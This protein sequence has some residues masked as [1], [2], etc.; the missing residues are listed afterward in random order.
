MGNGKKEIT[1]GLQ[2]KAKIDDALDSVKVLK[3]ELSGFELSKGI[4]AEF[5]KEFKKIETELDELQRKTA[6][7]EI[8][9]VDA[10]GA[11]KALDKIEKDWNYLVSKLSSQGL[12]GKTLKEDSAALHLLETLQNS[13]TKGIREAEAQ[14]LKLSKQLEKA[15]QHEQEILETQKDQHVVSQS[16]LKDQQTKASI[17][18]QQAK[19]ALKARK[20]AEKA[21]REKIAGSNGKYT[22]DDI[23]RKGSGLRKTEAYRNF[24]AAQAAHDAADKTAK[25][26]KAKTSA[27]VT[28]EMQTAAAQEARQAVEAANKALEDYKANALEVAK[29]DAF[30]K[31]KQSLREMAEFSSIDWG[32]LGIDLDE[33]KTIDELKEALS[34]LRVEAGTKVKASVEKMDD[35]IEKTSGNFRQMDKEVGEAKEGL[36]EYHKEASQTEA[37]EAKIK[38]FLGFAGAAQVLRNAVRDAMET[39]KELD[40][41][42]T[43]MA[44]VTDLTVGDYW[45]QLSEYSQQASDLGVSI[46]S[47]YK[48]ATLYYQQGLK[49]NEVTAISAETL[50]MA[51]IAGID[52][53]DATDKMTAALRGFNMELN[54]TSAQRV[55][56]VYSELAAITAADTQ[57]IANAM[58][59]TASIASNAGMEFETTAAFLSQIIE[60]TRESA[61]TAGTA[62]KTVI[63]RFQE[64]IK[65]PAEIGEV[66][67]EIVDANKIETA[68]RSV[69]VSLRD[70]SGQFRDLDDVF[71]ELSSKWDSLDTNTQRYIATI[72]A[73]SRQQSRFIAMMSN[74][75]RTQELVAAAN[76]SAGASNKQFE[77]TMESLEA[78]IAKLENAW[79]EF[80]MGIMNSDLVKAGV[81]IL[82]KLLEIIN[83]ATSGFNGM[84]GS[85]TKILGILT[86]FKLGK[87]IFNKLREPMVKFF[88]DIVR[89]AGA[90]GEKAGRAAQDGLNK[91][92]QQKNDKG[93]SKLPEG[94]VYDKN[95]RMHKNGKFI[96]ATEQRRI[97]KEL[98]AQEAQVPA[99][100]RAAGWVWEKTGGA[101]IKSSIT[102]I[103][104]NNK[105]RKANAAKIAKKQEEI[106]DIQF[107][108]DFGL[109]E[110]EAEKARAEIKGLESDIIGLEKEQANLADQ[111]TK[112]WES[113]GQGVQQAGAAVT[114]V[115]VAVSVL[116]GVF[117][118]LGL[119]EVGEAFSKIGNVVTLV[120]AGISTLGTVIPAV[121]AVA[122]AAGITTQ[123][124]WGW[125]GLILA[126]VAVLVTTVMLIFK[127]IED[128]DPNKKL[129]K[130][131]KAADAAADGAKRAAEA[132]NELNESLSSLDD[133]YKGLDEMTK[134]TEEWN[135]AVQDVNS[136][137]LDLIDKYPELAGFVEN[138]G[139][140]LTLDVDSAEVKD[141]MQAYKQDEIVAK[142]ASIGAKA[143]LARANADYELNTMD[144]KVFE[145]FQTD[146]QGAATWTAIGNLAAAT[147]LGAAG[148]AAIGAGT[149]ALVGAPVFGVGA[150]AGAGAGAIIGAI[151]GGVSGLIGGLASFQYTVDQVEK[152]NE[153]NRKNVE[154]L[155]QAYAN[156]ETGETVEEIADYIERNGI[157]VGDAAEQMAQSL[158][159]EAS[160][161]KEFGETLNAL[162][163]Q[164]K[165]YYQAMA[166]NA[167]QLLDL[168]TITEKEMNQINTV[169][170]ED[171]MKNQ[172]EAEKARL[173]AE[174][175]NKDGN[176]DKEKEDFAK[177]VYGDKARVDGNKILDEKGE[178]IREFD[179][180]E[181]WIN[182]MAAA[183]ATKE[184]AE[185]ME[186]IP[187]AIKNAIRDLSPTLQETFNK[188]FEGQ[189]LTRGEL[190]EFNKALGNVNY[191]TTD[192]DGNII[193][194]KKWAELDQQTKNLW[195]SE[196]AYLR[197]LDADYSGI[198]EMWKNLSQEQK[199]AY[200]W[201]GSSSDVEGLEKAK[202]AFEATYTEIAEAQT[203]AFEEAN[204]A[205]E[206]LGITLSENLSS[207]AAQAWATSLQEASYGAVSGEV[208]ALNE[209]LN[210]VLSGMTAEQANLVMA[211]INAMDKMDASAWENLGEVLSELE[212][213]PAAEALEALSIAG[214]N[215][216]N[217]IVKVDFDTLAQDINNIYKTL[218]KT[219]E[220]K[221]SYSESDYKELIAV[222]KALKDEFIQIGDEFLYVGGTMESLTEALERNTL[223]KLSEANR[224]LEDKIAM[225]EIVDAQDYGNVEAMGRNDLLNYLTNMRHDFATEGLDIADLGVT[226]LSNETNFSKL[227]DEQLLT[228][229]T[230]V[231]GEAGKKAVYE[232]D[233]QKQVYDANVLR[234]TRN[235]ASYNAEM[236]V[237]GGEYAKAHEDALIAQAIQ[238]GGVSN[239]LIEE[240][241]KATGETKK[242]LG[243]K[244]A[245][246]V[247]KVVKNS[248]GRDAYKE[249]INKVETAIKESHQKEIDKLSEINESIND[250]NQRLIDKIQEQI[251]YDRQ[252]DALEDA[253]ENL[254]D[255]YARQAYLGMDTSGANALEQMA[256]DEE[257][258]NAEKDLEQTLVD[259]AIQNL[260][261]A[262]EKAFEQRERQI[263]LMQEQL[264]WESENGLTYDKAKQAVDDSLAAMKADPTLVWNKTAMGEILAG[265]SEAK[266]F[267]LSAEDWESS[268]TTLATAAQNW[269]DLNPKTENTTGT[270][271][272]EPKEKPTDEEKT[273]LEEKKKA[274]TIANARSAAKASLESVTSGGFAGQEQ[275]KN[276]ELRKAYEA[277]KGAGGTG[278]LEQFAQDS[279]GSGK[280]IHMNDFVREIGT[281]Y[282]DR[283]WSNDFNWE[284]GKS[285]ADDGW[286]KVNGTDYKATIN[287]TDSTAR[288]VAVARGVGENELFKYANSYYIYHGDLAYKLTHYKSSDGWVAPKFKAGGLADFTGPA[289]LD[290]TKSRPEYVL[291]A[292][293]TERFFSLVDVL[294]KFNQNKVDTKTNGNGGD[295]HFDIKINVDKLESDYDVEQLAAKI[296]KM[297]YEDAAYR[298]VNAISLIR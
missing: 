20:D 165:A 10:K 6:S 245:E 279:L 288:S 174:A 237:D 275:D 126:G 135:K 216:Y 67:G 12:L 233:Y 220:G 276:S 27:M 162:D 93:P 81:D 110:K 196:E 53:A 8:S 173:Q 34:D 199:K 75:S 298:N 258:Q 172:E 157:A 78:K 117:S 15:K 152:N 278:S 226:G 282:T 39:I 169:F 235:D 175:E 292:A 106:D 83:K 213:A 55:S 41:T 112:A 208:T 164:E 69:G 287:G 104:A 21:L 76:N 284:D 230:A 224:Q 185:A 159:S 210:E 92:K 87:T 49:A 239:T 189:P 115:G 130:A 124:A 63:A 248:A 72:A 113:L 221:R 193:D 252:Q 249:I 95:G 2:I 251:D 280:N 247:D 19:D 188:A 228:M 158:I 7:G 161:M 73:G 56:D 222:N 186:Q 43:E 30:E 13:Y 203:K 89:E 229:A 176:F 94:Y 70:T 260:A 140:V 120:G 293:Q 82:T 218:D 9:L 31:A 272:E 211:E 62:M 234:Y 97:E 33:I 40:A 253:K 131:Q 217:A 197:S 180:D 80:T 129:E 256:V 138:E 266:L 64:L 1:I 240:Y 59:K 134:G 128:N 270:G 60:T 289:W 151:A 273:K 177:S 182:E 133:K 255:L 150:A 184:A 28:K 100:K 114:G 243:K 205:A 212:I 44:V 136:S 122:S 137:V 29:I 108:L 144:D 192:Q 47:A 4:A 42:M 147:T 153:Q 156:G 109:D 262:N 225:A 232:K 283:S 18:E 116:G 103:G 154:E 171:L 61:E 231:A 268:I 127:Q 295:N 242:E 191:K 91:S 143:E 206:G 238:S 141:I 101:Q 45:D 14:Q 263:T 207:S 294:E 274:E 267:G 170:D 259:Q 90:T 187:G 195:G 52:A 244:I 271:Q 35:A 23:T 139:G 24:A 178:V 201:S 281:A 236:S 54:E 17:A 227:S 166:L 246:G 3:D 46:N 269:I 290:G 36:E 96:D 219:K 250:V 179:S 22:A 181:A 125:I 84:A 148:G 86:V 119:E 296:R 98:E 68:L 200:G 77:K 167:Q 261:D 79:H 123:A 145:K 32:A 11:E 107:A 163:A 102:D 37:F 146:G 51:R 241:K 105:A 194:A 254:S 142:G 16:Q 168:G 71:I 111:G 155:A 50:K 25:E 132:Y 5:S 291:N 204:K 297:L 66:D 264:D 214:K 190:D 65:D 38:S 223:A 118:S 99:S 183:N 215:A 58:T 57:E 265:S 88:A 202:E 209:A 85:I 48:A 26:E 257:I 198:D 121:A 160:T 277:Y 285:K 286:I 74:Y 149:G